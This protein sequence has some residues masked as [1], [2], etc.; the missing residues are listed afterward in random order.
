MSFIPKP[1]LAHSFPMVHSLSLL[2]LFVVAE[3]A[4]SHGAVIHPSVSRSEM[5]AKGYDDF[6]PTFTAF[7]TTAVATKRLLC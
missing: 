7:N 3:H 1:P 5:Y 6:Y 2:L 4:G